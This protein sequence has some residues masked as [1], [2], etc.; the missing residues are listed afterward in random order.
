MDSSV[1]RVLERLLA[2]LDRLRLGYRVLGYPENSR[3]RSVDVLVTGGGR[4]VF[5]KVVEDV[6][7]VRREDVREL[8]GL[9]SV[10][11][12]AP[13]LVADRERG[14]KLEDI[15]AYEKMGVYALSPEGFERA[16]EEG[17]YVV[18]KRGRF[19]MRI[20]AGRFREERERRGLSLGSIAS[21]IGAT[22]RAVY[23]YE[24]SSM[25]VELGKALRLLELL[26]EDIFAP[27]DVFRVEE[28]PPGGI[29]FD[30]EGERRMAERIV[31]EGGVVTHARR[32]FTDMAA[33]L[34]GTSQII[35]YEHRGEGG[36]SV[37]KRGEAAAEV[38]EVFSSERIA[39]VKGREAAVN[40]E[41]MGFEVVKET[42][43]R[44]VK[45]G[46]GEGLGR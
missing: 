19:Y 21:L 20:D 8:R 36:D 5:I 43:V 15:V 33:R 35:V 16:L 38:A 4:K 46:Q 39:V 45:R 40:L 18:R 32:A 9:G 42:E 23:E 12:A 26:G 2:V 31:E 30:E 17:V 25:D 1:D 6:G 44:L 41:A 24:R 13:L 27:I 3:R 10:L 37:V 34:G 28:K 11:G 22:R 29:E 7:R 14:E